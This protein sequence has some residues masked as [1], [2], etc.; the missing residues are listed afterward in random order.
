MA[1]AVC[2]LDARARW[3]VTGTPVQNRLSDF[4]ALLQFIRAHPYDDPRLFD[5]DIANLWK[6]GEESQA[7]Q[8]LKRLSHHLLLRRPNDTIELPARHDLL[9]P[10]TFTRDE[11][12]V[13]EKMRTQTLTVLGDALYSDSN[14][15]KPRSHMN[16][17]Q[18]IESLRLFC[19][20]GLQFRAQH[21]HEEKSIER[22]LES[23]AAVAQKAFHAQW[24][25]SPMVCLQCDSTFEI[26][27]SLSN[28]DEASSQVVHFSSCLKF[29][30]V[31]CTSKLNR[32]NRAFQC[33]H[34]PSCQTA[35]VSLN[36]AALDD[37]PSLDNFG[38]DYCPNDGLSSKVQ[39]LISD[40]KSRPSDE[41]WYVLPT[42][43]VDRLII[44]SSSIVFSTWRLTLDMVEK[45]LNEAGVSC[46]RF[47]GKVPQKDRQP[48]VEKF[49]RDAN[50]RVMLLTLACGAVG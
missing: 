1:K 22:P 37:V 4:S 39:A 5:S 18:H 45:G 34:Q 33:G 27:E 9:C 19:T 24:A 20:L 47:D 26:A 41:K 13:Y 2:A 6:Y 40:I 3:A 25:M 11:K 17:L 23:W 44:N 10:V 14:S 15:Y 46:V 21:T 43:N 32:H 49:K 8:R 31:S 29:A 50:I 7:V 48:I 35:L 16:A 36:N 30:C 38:L 42:K 12:T 28:G